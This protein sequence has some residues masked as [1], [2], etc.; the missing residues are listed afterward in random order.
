MNNRS[1][2]LTCALQLFAK[3]GYDAVGV[4]EIVDAAGI[5]KPTLYHYFGSKQGLLET[6]LSE[7]LSDFIAQ[8]EKAADYQRDL[9]S[10]LNRITETYFR[11]ADGHRQIY[12][13][14]LAMWFAPPH[15][16]AL[17][18]ITPYNIR[19]QE[20]IERVFLLATNDHG[21]MK[22]RHQAYASTF[23]GMINT[24]IGLALNG[25]LV[26]DEELVHRAVHQFMHGIYS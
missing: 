4:Q 6:L 20:M 16:D 25:Y 13:L 24:Y 21:N 17:R 18:A 10:T 3:R 11:F 9:P 1:K 26:L 12:R 5:T 14:Q 23:L 19:Q 7:R 2:I 22:G 15:G 8:I